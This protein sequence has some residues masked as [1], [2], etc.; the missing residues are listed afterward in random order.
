MK[1]LFWDL[2][3]HLYHTI[4]LLDVESNQEEG[5]S[6]IQRGI[7]GEGNGTPIQSSCLENPRDGGAWRAAISGVAQSRT[8]LKRLGGSSSREL[9]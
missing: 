9:S 5:I 3:S 2:H 7:L 4:L 8:R 6:S 1:P